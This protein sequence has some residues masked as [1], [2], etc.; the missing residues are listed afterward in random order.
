MSH[1]LKIIIQIIQ[2][3]LFSQCE[4]RIREHLFGLKDGLGTREALFCMR[5]LVQ[6]SCELRK[7]VSVCFID[8]EKAF[9]GVLHDVLFEYLKSAA[10]VSYDLRLFKYFY[11]IQLA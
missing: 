7:N 1:S 5:I 6:K 10:L 4:S 2:N 11:Y 8:F 3:Q 9:G